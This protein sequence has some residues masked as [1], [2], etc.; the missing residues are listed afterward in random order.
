[1]KYIYDDLEFDTIEEAKEYIEA[2]T[3][4]DDVVEYMLE[5]YSEDEIFDMLKIYERVRIK[6][7]LIEELAEKIEEVEEEGEPDFDAGFADDLY[8]DD[9]DDDNDNDNDNDD[10]N[11]DD[12][13]D[14][15]DDEDGGGYG[16]NDESEYI[17]Y[18]TEDAYFDGFE[19]GIDAELFGPFH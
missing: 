3:F 9:N 19:S 14:D 1:M 5:N 15:D 16:S 8:D 7:E 4:D 13:D 6:E 12:D 10:D 2:L 11:D 18:A 17:D